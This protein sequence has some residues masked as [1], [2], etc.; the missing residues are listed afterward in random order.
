[1]FSSGNGG[2]IHVAKIDGKKGD[3]EKLNPHKNK[4]MMGVWKIH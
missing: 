4:K 3:I 2:Y 1:M